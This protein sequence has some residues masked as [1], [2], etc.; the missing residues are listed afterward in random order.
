MGK[1]L[2]VAAPP[3]TARQ[4]VR[5]APQVCGR[6][7][8][9]ASDVRLG[10][11][12]PVRRDCRDCPMRHPSPTFALALLSPLAA[13][14]LGGPRQLRSSVALPPRL[15]SRRAVCLIVSQHERL[16]TSA[17]D[18]TS[19]WWSLFPPP[20]RG[21]SARQPVIRSVVFL[22]LGGLA[23]GLESNPLSLGSRICA[24]RVGRAVGRGLCRAPISSGAAQLC[25]ST[26]AVMLRSPR[27]VAAPQVPPTD[28]AAQSM[29]APGGTTGL[30]L[31]S[32]SQQPFHW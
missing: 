25:A 13:G 32:A 17:P 16:S 29:P 30:V 14:T 31:L 28:G 24:C 20:G 22:P 7:R 9:P 1:L 15:A 5:R 4:A 18:D 26:A 21:P 2:G 27:A 11:P 6:A 12:D 3:C 10:G 23:P 8:R 19:G